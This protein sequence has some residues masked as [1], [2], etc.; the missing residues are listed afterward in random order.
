MS[1]RPKHNRHLNEPPI[2]TGF[3]PINGDYELSDPVLLYLEEYESIKLSDYE[4]LT[5]L[6][7]SK[8]LQVSRPTFTRI[9]NS[10]RQKVAKAFV[11]NKRISIEGG[12]VTF[13]DNWYYC[14]C[15]N[16]VFRIK[17]ISITDDTCCPVCNCMSTSTIQ[18]SGNWPLCFIKSKR[19]KQYKH[20]RRI[21]GNCICPKCDFTI[22]HESGVPCSSLLCPDCDIRMICENSEHHKLILYKRKNRIMKKIALPTEGGKLSHHFGHSREFYFI[23][24]EDNK[25]IATYVKEPPPHAAGTIPRWLIA[26][27]V[28]DLLVGGIGPKAIDLLYA[29]NINVYIGV[30]TDTPDN[31]A[32]NFINGK[33]KY[34]QNY[35]HH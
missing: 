13:K 5:Q 6:E 17:D 33:L 32:L 29:A 19:K 8:R 34:G 31:L 7:A 16:T 26:E 2:V 4:G 14:D 3:V 21:K 35:C 18:N 28:T 22:P 25:I 23:E 11:E 10:A 24:I 27:S 15:C 12:N 9:Y 30:E 1:P 20:G